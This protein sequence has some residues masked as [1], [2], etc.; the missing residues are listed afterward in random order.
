ME[1]LNASK[2]FQNMPMMMLSD[3]MRNVIV[4]I[5][6]LLHNLFLCVEGPRT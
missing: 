2:I 6:I 3:V 4:L 1:A 5:M